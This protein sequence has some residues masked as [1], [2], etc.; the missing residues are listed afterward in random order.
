M[1]EIPTTST[2]FQ[3]SE[4]VLASEKQQLKTIELVCWV[5]VHLHTKIQAATMAEQV[6]TQ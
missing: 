4:N 3:K 2:T 6:K 1:C 5:K